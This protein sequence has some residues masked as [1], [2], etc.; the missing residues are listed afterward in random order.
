MSAASM[1]LL[2]ARL[3]TTRAELEEVIGHL[4]Q[5]LSD[6]APR[7]G[8]RTVSGQLIEIAATEVQIISRLKSNIS[9]PFEEV[10]ET[11]GDGHS[12]EN[13][14]KVL[15]SVR[16][17]TMTYI[18]EL[19]E[20]GLKAVDPHHPDWFGWL[21]LSEVPRVEILRGIAIHEAY[22]TGQLVSYLWAR[23]DNPY[24]WR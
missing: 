13:L 18:N 8:M 16:V 5:S 6:W 12:L 4:T 23:G 1:D 11:F 2:K 21:G 17:D 20:D 10:G 24:N 3:I 14:A 15:G 22:H 9:I 7:P 19:G